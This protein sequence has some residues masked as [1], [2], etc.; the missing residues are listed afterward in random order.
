MSLNFFYL[1]AAHISNEEPTLSHLKDDYIVMEILDARLDLSAF[2][3]I[4]DLSLNF[5]LSFQERSNILNSVLACREFFTHLFKWRPDVKLLDLQF[6]VE[7]SSLLPNRTIFKKINEDIRDGIVSLSL[8]NT[9]GE[10]A[11]ND[12]KLYVKENIVDNL[13]PEEGNL[14]PNWKHIG[15][16]HGYRRSELMAISNKHYSTESKTAKLLSLLCEKESLPSL[17]SF[18][19]NCRDIKRNDIAGLLVDWC[20]RVVS[21]VFGKS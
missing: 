1:A 20:N 7:E 19:Q 10:L 8:S 15:S 16:L 13:A 3:N 17:S 18:I 6:D 9:L 5:P 21:T 14:L 12:N 11:T 2:G 4:K